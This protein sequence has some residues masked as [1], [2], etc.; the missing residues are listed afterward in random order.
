[1]GL[2]INFDWSNWPKGFAA[3]DDE[4][5]DFE[6]ITEVDLVKMLAI[7]MRKD[8]FDNGELVHQF[9]RGVMKK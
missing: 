2:V 6:T 4:S 9:N 7:I 5:T 1:M 8:H 3:I